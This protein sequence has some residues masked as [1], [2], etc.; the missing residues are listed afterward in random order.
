MLVEAKEQSMHRPWQTAASRRILRTPRSAHASGQRW[1]R[2]RDR[3]GS[4]SFTL[5]VVQVVI[6]KLPACVV[7]KSPI[8]LITV[9]VGRSVVVSFCALAHLA[10]TVVRQS[11][12]IPKDKNTLLK[13]RL[14]PQRTTAGKSSEQRLGNSRAYL[15]A[16]AGAGTGTGTRNGQSLRASIARPLR[17]AASICAAWPG[18]PCSVLLEGRGQSALRLDD[19]VACENRGMPR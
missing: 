3:V 13:E 6:G 12:V 18:G 11:S 14:S 9:T 8:L 10:S 2:M 15:G 1:R 7:S 17:C 5:C 16:G 19:P 4:G